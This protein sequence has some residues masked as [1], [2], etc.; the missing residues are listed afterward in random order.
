MF[1][2]AIWKVY[3]ISR[4][5]NAAWFDAAGQRTITRH[6]RNE[7]D[8]GSFQDVMME[9]LRTKGVQLFHR[10]KLVMMATDREFRWYAV[11]GGTLTDCFYEAAR[12]YPKEENVVL[13]LEQGLDDCVL[14]HKATP[15]DIVDYMIL[16]HNAFHD[17]APTTFIQLCPALFIKT[18][19]NLRVLKVLHPSS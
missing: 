17:G 1:I 15:V 6:P 7:R 19:H 13:S 18:L 5:F 12:L 2:R 11:G 14:I 4:N 10:G 9:K 16:E 8:V 3:V